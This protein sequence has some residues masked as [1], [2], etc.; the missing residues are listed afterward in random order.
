MVNRT[1]GLV[2]RKKP[3]RTYLYWSAEAVSKTAAGYPEKMIPIPAN[4][5][6]A[7]IEAF[8]QRET[9]R[10]RLWLA[11]ETEEAPIYSGTIG[12]V[13][14]V[15]ERHRDSPIRDVKHNTANFYMDALKVV[16]ANVAERAVA[17]THGIDVKRWFEGWRK[18]AEDG[19]PE[20]LRRAHAAVST[21]RSALRFCQALGF[22]DCER[23]ANEIAGLR[24]PKP[25]PRRAEMTYAHAKV[26]VEY[27]T[28]QGHHGMAIGIA[29]QFELGVRQKDVIGEHYAGQ[30][31]GTF[32]WENIAGAGIWRLRTSKTKAPAAF[33]LKTYDLLWPLLQAVPQA[34]RTGPIVKNLSGDPIRESD[35]R[36]KYRRLARQAGIP[37]DVWNMDARAGAAT[38][39]LESGVSIEDVSRS[40]THASERMTRSYER[41][42]YE[43][44][45]LVA[46]AR[47]R[48]RE[49]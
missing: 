35:Y 5:S 4:Y 13:C 3:N 11:G 40:L 2:R 6:E 26:F 24:F 36:K 33:D 49:G 47:K 25:E 42:N 27:A 18:P 22:K 15:F 8:C 17:K 21:L 9:A 30:W 32:T 41:R 28:A 29:A 1:P 19:G 34:E 20:R 16:K 43:S 39:A 46:E 7:Q 44:I 38:E 23:L 37:D 14:N 10:L 31:R 45:R 12:S 48:S